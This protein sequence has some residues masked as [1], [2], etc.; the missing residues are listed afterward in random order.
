MYGGII[1]HEG[2]VLDIEGNHNG[3]QF[4]VKTG[5]E[6]Q[7]GLGD[8]VGIN[9]VCLTVTK[10]NGDSLCFDVWPETLKRTTLDTVEVNQTVHVDLPLKAGDF[11]G[12]HSILG[13]VDYTAEVLE[14]TQVPGSTQVKIWFT[15]PAQYDAL[16]PARGCVSVD[17]VSLTITDRKASAF[18]V[19][20]IPETLERTHLDTVQK[21]SKVN[22]EVDYNSR[23]FIDDTGF[24]GL[25]IPRENQIHAMDDKSE[26]ITAALKAGS[27]VIITEEQE[28]RFQ[29]AIVAPVE[30]LN[31]QVLTFCQGMARSSCTITVSHD[32]AEQLVI[33]APIINNK[34]Y[35]ED[36][37]RYLVPISHL[38]N[39][40]GDESADATFK[41]L[42]LFTSEDQGPEHWKT[43]GNVSAIQIFP[44]FVEKEYHGLPEASI[45]LMRANGYQDCSLFMLLRDATG[46]FATELQIQAFAERYQIP[47]INR[48]EIKAQGSLA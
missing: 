37:R 14:N 30:K 23:N 39:I 7:V 3:K 45:H 4:T 47:I 22:I 10:N 26:W 12:G 11:I 36:G 6:D 28:N 2:T 17:G 46:S 8:S 40:D 13:H 41:T 42:S 38:D 48:V 5:I 35:D 31:A 16:L 20:L 34:S 33:P 25:R 9:G 21:G 43:P 18:S 29:A 24:L 32:V 44:E 1:Y 27:P 15:I 19:S